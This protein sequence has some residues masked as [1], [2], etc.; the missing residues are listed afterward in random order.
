ML[1]GLFVGG[2]GATIAFAAPFHFHPIPGA[3]AR[4]SFD[5]GELR[6]VENRTTYSFHPDNF[7]PPL[8]KDI[9]SGTPVIIWIDRS[10]PD[11][12]ALQTIGPGRAI[13][14]SY[15]DDYF[16]HPALHLRE[17]RV[18]GGFF[19]IMGGIC[20]LGSVFWLLR[21]RIRGD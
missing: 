17:N 13:Q 9:P 15:S 18:Y 11:I 14:A 7:R 12:D 20:F 3:I 1:F 2:L 19:A 6:L 21:T 16:D 10:Y 5:D 8:P 4:Y